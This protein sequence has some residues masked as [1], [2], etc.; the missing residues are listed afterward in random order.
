MEFCSCRSNRFWD[1]GDDAIEG[2]QQEHSA[3]SV[4]Q[5]FA[6][7]RML[8]DWPITGQVLPTNPAAAV[9]GPKDVVKTG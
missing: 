1:P 2:L 8:F 3:P 7:V 5:Q 4:K 6:A 9:R